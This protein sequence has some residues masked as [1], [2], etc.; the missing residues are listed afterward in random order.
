MVKKLTTFICRL[1]ANVNVRNVHSIQIA[2]LL[3]Y[4]SGAS[5]AKQPRSPLAW[6]EREI[7]R[8]KC[9]YA[10]VDGGRY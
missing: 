10:Q 1:D 2:A 8:E 9:S 5:G 4:N 3:H 7:D 6:T